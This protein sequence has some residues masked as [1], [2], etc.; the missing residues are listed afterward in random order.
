MSHIELPAIWIW[1]AIGL[2]HILLCQL[3]DEVNRRTLNL[4]IAL[5]QLAWVVITLGNGSPDETISAALCRMERAGKLSGRLFRPL[6][7]L[8]FRPLEREHC[9]KAYEA[10]KRGAQLPKEYRV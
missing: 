4:L 1:I 7:D 10:E 2:A 9:R 3:F 6:I 5:D 8:L